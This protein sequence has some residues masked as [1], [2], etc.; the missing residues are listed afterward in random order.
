MDSTNAPVANKGG[1][2]ATVPVLESPPPA[3]SKSLP[4]VAE[5]IRH[6]CQVAPQQYLNEVQARGGGE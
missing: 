3:R 6:D 2:T 4:Q 5:E 1:D